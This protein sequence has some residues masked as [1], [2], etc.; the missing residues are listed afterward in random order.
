MQHRH[1]ACITGLLPL[2]F[3][4]ATPF[5]DARVVISEVMWAGSDLSSA[6]EWVE[7]VCVKDE[8]ELCDLSG[9]SLTYLDSK[10]VEQT[11]AAFAAGTIIGNGKYF[12]VSNFAEPE[13]RLSIG[14]DLVTSA[15]SIPNTKLLLRLRDASGNIVDE[16]DDG[17]GDPFAGLNQTGT[18]G[19]KAS[20]ERLD[21]SISGIVKLNWITATACSNLDVPSPLRGTPGGAYA[22]I[23]CSESLPSSSSILSSSSFSSLS[24]LRQA[25]DDTS[26]FITEVLPNPEGADTDE[27]IEIG[28]L[29]NTPAVITGLTLSTGTGSSKRSFIIP[30]DASGGILLPGVYRSFRSNQTRLTLANAGSSVRL[31]SSSIVLDELIYPEVPEGMSYGRDAGTGDR[32]M[33]CVPTERA[34][35]TDLPIGLSIVVQSGELQGTEDVTVN[36]ASTATHTTALNGALCRWDYPDGYKPETCNP[37]SH[38]LSSSGVHLITLQARLACGLEEKAT[39]TVRIDPEVRLSKTITQATS[40]IEDSS[41][42]ILSAVMPHGLSRNV[43]WVS[44][45]NT[46]DDP[47]DILDFSLHGGLIPND[48]YTFSSLQL[49]PREERRFSLDFLRLDLP[50]TAELILRDPEGELQSILSWDDESKNQIIRPPVHP[51]GSI[52]VKVLRVLDGDTLEIALLD[53]NDPDIPSSVLQ[54]W[55]RQEL[56]DSA[57]L[58]LRLIGIDAP[59]LFTEDG[60]IYEQGLQALKFA[61]A[62]IENKNI[63]LQFDAILWDKYERILAYARLPDYPE[64]IQSALLKSGN[65]FAE[66]EFDHPMRGE[67]IVL[68]VEAKSK[69]NGIWAKAETPKVLA[70]TAM[71]FSSKSFFS[72]AR[73]TAYSSSRTITSKVH[74]QQS[75]TGKRPAASAAGWMKV[76]WAATSS[77]SVSPSAYTGVLTLLNRWDDLSS[78][79]AIEVSKKPYMPWYKR[80]LNTFCLFHCN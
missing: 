34:A 31:L 16:V 25:Q 12:L 66:K 48:H 75:N 9:W 7:I 73:S 2:I 33:F 32:K 24:I 20:M 62:L 47:I 41:N 56:S 69:K 22:P 63:E 74:S 8:E 13:S 35:N 18:G 49:L 30:I 21:F 54:R 4:V 42:L 29:G 80:M 28:N 17:I 76:K 39:V 68:E 65:A 55:R 50:K 60:S 15:V 43:G 77:S 36:L 78:P 61:S 38:T 46:G 52:T 59:E 58:R 27:W 11:M 71:V 23:A 10:S 64:T 53:T 40:T 19:I 6:D 67:Y 26:L 5:A 1:F 70:D 57:S 3:F 37:P 14:P 45:R 51:L 72:F 44:L 79:N